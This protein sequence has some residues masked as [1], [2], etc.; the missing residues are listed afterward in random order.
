MKWFGP[1]WHAPVCDEAQHIEIPTEPCHLCGRAFVDGDQGVLW[2]LH[3]GGITDVTYH[4]ACL[5]VICGYAPLVHVL[6]F[7][8]PLCGFSSEVPSKWSALHK[9]VN[10]R[11]AETANCADCI[12]ASLSTRKP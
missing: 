5:M 8:R 11:D 7:G 6:H 1:S 2:P 3:R 10:L 12:K 9:W 4:R